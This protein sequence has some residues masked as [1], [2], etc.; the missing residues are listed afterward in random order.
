M[1]EFVDP[2]L[3][4]LADLSK[5]VME[6]TPKLDAALKNLVCVLGHRYVLSYLTTMIAL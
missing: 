4:V 2:E 6:E 3:E 5:E 1:T